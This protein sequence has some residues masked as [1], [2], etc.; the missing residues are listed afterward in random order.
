MQSNSKVYLESLEQETNVSELQNETS[1]KEKI[2]DKVLSDEMK[3]VLYSTI[4]VLILGL[5]FTLRLND[6]ELKRTKK[7]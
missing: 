4:M 7:E 1:I 2:V 5:I 6:K 3:I